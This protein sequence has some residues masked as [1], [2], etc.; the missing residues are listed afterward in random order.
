MN[1]VA[2]AMAAKPVYNVR[3]LEQDEQELFR[4]IME[5]FNP[6]VRRWL[7]SKHNKYRAALADLRAGRAIAGVDRGNP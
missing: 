4:D 2:R 7:V 6:D 5:E 1:E 3:R